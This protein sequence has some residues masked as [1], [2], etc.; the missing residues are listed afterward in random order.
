ML[1]N[2]DAKVERVCKAYNS[3]D[4]DGRIKAYRFV[5]YAAVT[6]S[7]VAVLS[8][9]ITLPLVYNYARHIR[10]VAHHELLQCKVSARDVLED[11]T[12]LP[13]ANRTTRSLVRRQYEEESM[14]APATSAPQGPPPAAVGGYSPPVSTAT[15]GYSA[16][17][18]AGAYPA[19]VSTA[20]SGYSPPTAAVGGGYSS[21]TSAVSGNYCQGCCLP[22]PQG[23]PGPPGRP[24]RPGK[25]GAPGAPGNP[26][27]PPQ[28]PCEPITPPPCRP[29]PPGPPGPPGETGPA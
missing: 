10:R 14:E 5:G 8:V 28:L 21:A 1:V 17:S 6:F 12:K 11:A 23:P 13:E 3:M 19:P 2:V 27:R 16:S 18:G 7:A 20:T 15:S 26:G 4:I 29:C 22:G 9:C 25:A 24:G